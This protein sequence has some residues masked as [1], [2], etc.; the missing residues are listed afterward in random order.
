MGKKFF[1]GLI[2]LALIVQAYLGVMIY[3]FI[4]LLKM[5]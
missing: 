2:I 1:I 5:V 3:N 4:N